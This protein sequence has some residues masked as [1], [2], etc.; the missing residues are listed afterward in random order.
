MGNSAFF[1]GKQQIPQH[2]M[3]I[4][5]LHTAGPGYGLMLLPTQASTDIV[6]SKN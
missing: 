5:V 1:R 3:K 6:L 4:R 2:G